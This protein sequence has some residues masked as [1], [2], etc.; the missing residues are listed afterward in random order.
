MFNLRIFEGDLLDPVW[1]GPDEITNGTSA[2]G[3]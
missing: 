2:N 1:H 3:I